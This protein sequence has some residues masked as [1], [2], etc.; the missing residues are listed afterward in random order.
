MIEQAWPYLLVMAL[1]LLVL[2]RVLTVGW[3]D[4][5]ADARRRLARQLNRW[6]EKLVPSPVCEPADEALAE[7]LISRLN[8][9]AR[10][11]DVLNALAWLVEARVIVDVRLC[12]H[13]TI[14][15]QQPANGQP[16][17]GFL[18]MLNGIVGALPAGPRRGYP[19]IAAVFDGDLPGIHYEPDK[20]YPRGEVPMH[21]IGFEMVDPDPVES[22]PAEDVP[23]RIAGLEGAR[24]TERPTRKS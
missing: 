2:T 3:V 13:P 4:S 11:P 17:V 5:A 15:V 9:L 8:T 19:Y 1:A 21:L 20:V 6:S 23:Y 10:D 22:I 24:W 14:Q 12:D 18:D 7:V 16:C